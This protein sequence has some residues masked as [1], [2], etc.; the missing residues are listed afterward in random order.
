M[1]HYHCLLSATLLNF[2]INGWCTI[3]ENI[4]FQGSITEFKREREANSF[5]ASEIVHIKIAMLDDK[6]GFSRGN[7]RLNEIQSAERT[8]DKG[9]CPEV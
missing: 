5:S 4:K 2:K 3:I 1:I 9:V 6:S 7:L 8:Q